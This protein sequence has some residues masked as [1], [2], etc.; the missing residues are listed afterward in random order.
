VLGF[1]VCITTAE[2]FLPILKYTLST[3]GCD[4]ECLQTHCFKSCQTYDTN[5][6]IT[7]LG[8]LGPHAFEHCSSMAN[9]T[10]VLVQ[11]TQTLSISSLPYG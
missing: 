11:E 9:S 10:S 8:L 6:G 1:L 2:Q 7:G 4:K 3:E 5:R